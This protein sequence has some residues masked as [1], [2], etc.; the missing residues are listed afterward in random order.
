[1]PVFELGAEHLFPSPELT[2]PSGLLAVGGDLHPERILL[3]YRNGI[4]PWFDRSS[5]VLWWSPDPR[6]VLFPENLHISRSLKKVLKKSDFKITLDENFESVIT[7]C[8]YSRINNG[9]ET[10]ITDDMID[11]Y[12]KLHSS[13]FAHSVEVWKNNELAAGIYGVSIG[14]VF[15]G[16]SMFTKVPDGSKTGFV[17]LVKQ[18]EKWGFFMID[19]QVETENL[20]RFGA[21]N[22]PRKEFLLHLDK[23]LDS[24]YCPYGKW[25][26]DSDFKLE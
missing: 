24:S 16:E 26:F 21:L 3:A 12:V 22:I 6:M 5:P 14:R 1:M 19:C 18:L 9:E 20:Q 10:W 11:A 25:K 4:F 15:C 13:G 2:E 8:A 7:G 17:Y 23:N